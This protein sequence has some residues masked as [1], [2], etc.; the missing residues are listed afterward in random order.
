MQSCAKT[1]YLTATSKSLHETLR[2][3]SCYLIVPAPPGL[4]AALCSGAD[5]PVGPTTLCLLTAWLKR[6]HGN[7]L[8]ASFIYLF[9]SPSRGLMAVPL[10][11]EQSGVPK[12]IRLEI[13][14]G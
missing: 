2:T 7:T 8:C 3:E 6:R 14:A 11:R 4:H 1:T 12:S 10:P 9:T 5:L 13:S